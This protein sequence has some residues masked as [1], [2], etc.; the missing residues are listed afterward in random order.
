MQKMT[1]EQIRPSLKT[2][3]VMILKG[4]AAVSRGIM[5]FCAL[6]RWAA[7]GFKKW[8]WGYSHV[9]MIVILTVGQIN[10][11]LHS[12]K[13]S[14]E[15]ADW[16]RKR[17]TGENGCKYDLTMAWESTLQDGSKGVRLVPLSHI[18]DTYKG[19]IFIEHLVCQRTPGMMEVLWEYIE[20]KIN[21]PYEKHPI[22]LAMSAI[23]SPYI[24]KVD[25]SDFSCSELV[26]NSFQIMRLL[27]WYPPANDYVPDDIVCGGRL[28]KRLLK[29]AMIT[30]EIE[31]QNER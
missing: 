19:R 20:E 5:F 8:Q 14:R 13:L 30:K 18:I 4:E 21:W 7:S 25:N 3:D 23:K 12:G 9:L 31:I 29:G 22:E 2:G 11:L 1:Y 27:P 6:C 24:Q 10:E 28:A 15:T 26:A 16:L 17:R